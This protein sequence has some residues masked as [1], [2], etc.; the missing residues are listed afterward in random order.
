MLK[1]ALL[2][3]LVT[4]IVVEFNSKYINN[5]IN[6]DNNIVIYDMNIHRSTN[7]TNDKNIHS[8]IRQIIMISI[9][10]KHIINSTADTY[11]I[12]NNNTANSYIVMIVLFRTLISILR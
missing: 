6:K 3:I 8:Y 10:I 1:I 4:I 9:I 11:N 12:D 7:N 2:A 5:N